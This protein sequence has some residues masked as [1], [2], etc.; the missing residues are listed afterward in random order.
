MGGMKWLDAL[1]GRR[2]EPRGVGAERRCIDCEFK[3]P[4]GTFLEGDCLNGH[5]YPVE[6]RVL[7]DW[8]PALQSLISPGGS[9]CDYWVKEYREGDTYVTPQGSRIETGPVPPE[10]RIRGAENDALDLHMPFREATEGSYRR[11]VGLECPPE[12]RDG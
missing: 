4:E 2:K 6:F 8:G 12:G 7:P 9:N 1:R 5:A 3:G 11:G 10:K